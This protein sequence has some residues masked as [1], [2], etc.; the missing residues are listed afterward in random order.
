MPAGLNPVQA[1]RAAC[2]A[3]VAVVPARK[4]QDTR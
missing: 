2:Y 4:L 3:M 1:D